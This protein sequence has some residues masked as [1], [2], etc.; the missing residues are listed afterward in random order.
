VA[1]GL[2]VG[3]AGAG[4]VTWVLSRVFIGIRSIEVHVLLHAVLL[5]ALVALAAALAP[6]GRAAGLDP[7]TALRQE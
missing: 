2:A 6:A 4:I 1:A 3:V 5:L 7:A